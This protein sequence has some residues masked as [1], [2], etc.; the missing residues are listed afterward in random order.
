MK[1]RFVIYVLFSIAMV[2]QMHSSANAGFM[3]T[4]KNGRAIPADNY[5]AKGDTIVIFFEVLISFRVL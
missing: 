5:Q 4:M 2:F 3:I 1:K